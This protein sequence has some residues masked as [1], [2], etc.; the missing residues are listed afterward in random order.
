MPN[1]ENFIL[2]IDISSNKIKVG[3][4]SETLKLSPT[5]SQKLRINNEDVDGFAKRF[6][7]D[8]LWNKVKMSIRE[9]IRNKTEN[10]NIIGISSCAQRMA[11]VFIDNQ[12]KVIY[13][14]PNTDVRGID[15]AYLIEDEFS[16]DELFQITGHCPPILFC[17]ARLL[18]F[19]EEREKSYNQIDKVLMLDD[20]IVY[21]L[22]GEHYS[23][24][25]SAGESQLIDI[26]KRNWSLDIIETFD[27]N[28]DF[29]PELVDPGTNVGELKPNLVNYFK[30]LQKSV[31]VM[32]TGADTQANLLG[33]GAIE[34][35]NI[36]ISLGSTAPIQLVLNEPI[37]DPN[38]NFWTT[39]HSLK[40]KWIIEAHPGNTGIVYDWLKDNM[41]KG[42]RND[43][44][45]NI[46][47][48]L[49][50]VKPGSDST[51]AFLGPEMMNIKDQTSLKRGVFVFPP[52]TLIA[53]TLPKIENFVRSVIENI[54]FGIN[55]NFI[56][57]TRFSSFDIKTYCAGGMA[58]SKE[59]CQIL[60]NI[61]NHNINVPQ[62][63]DSSFIG[64]AMNVL[65]GLNLYQDYQKIIGNLLEFESFSID[66]YIS[67]E[68]KKLFREWQ[69]LKKQVSKI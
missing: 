69:N 50:E 51:F 25:T 38:C 28:P 35:G 5:L 11:V 66:E 3:L 12:G 36:G 55:E 14:G 60:T 6:D 54:C 21:K 52:P 48:L 47:S 15:S 2:A 4:V 57:L 20:W 43:K 42:I 23:D 39:F 56:E 67:N 58:K 22:T 32:K 46:E 37:L 62:F 7:M 65:I 19:K 9:L 64:C 61:L 30:I 33:M 45:K 27:F 31:P 49:K 68:Y 24:L 10:I 53:E 18:W 13:G 29:F 41:L 17:L 40:G 59:F 1:S 44:D 16:E 8:D 63:K 26:K 34:K